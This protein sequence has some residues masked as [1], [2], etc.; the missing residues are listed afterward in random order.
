MAHN[1][2]TIN[3]IIIH[4]SASREDKDYSFEQLIKDHKA[5][6]FDAC[7]YHVFFSK[8]GTR[9]DGRPFNTRGAH[10][11]PFNTNSIGICYEGGVSAKGK[12]KDT[13]TEIQ[14]EKLLETILE[15]LALIKKAGGNPKLVE[16]IGHR[17]ISPDLDGDGIVE[18]FEWIK[19]CPCFEAKEEYK[20]IAKTF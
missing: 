14:K 11:A 13:R 12:P 3:K 17:D 15:V 1:I 9:H 2:K 10:A 16:I 6:G 7:G 20:D 19:S 4:C 18:P 5:R 8:D